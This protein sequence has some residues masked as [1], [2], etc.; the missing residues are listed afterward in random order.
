ML[1]IKGTLIAAL[2]LA[3]LACDNSSQPKI[4]LVS[5]IPP[6]LG[7]WCFEPNERELGAFDAA[8]RAIEFRNGNSE[9]GWLFNGAMLTFGYGISRTGGG[10]TARVCIPEAIRVRLE[11]ALN[12]GSGLG[13]GRPVDYQLI[14]AAELSTPSKIIVDQ[15]AKVAFYNSIQGGEYIRQMQDIR[16]LALTVLAGFGEKAVAYQEQAVRNMN[17]QTSLGTGAA[18]VAVA[19]GAPDALVRV[20]E[21]LNAELDKSPPSKPI[22]YET[23]NRLLELAW[24]IYLAGPSAKNYVQG[25]HKIMNRKVESPAPPFGMLASD[26]YLFCYVLE[27]IEGEQAIQQYDFCDAQKD[28]FRL[29]GTLKVRRSS[30]WGE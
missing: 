14:V 3:L 25:I 27:K 15:V 30:G 13:V 29:P 28:P 22:P 6:K 17:S 26:P 10:Y 11:N 2:A 9:G 12:S 21:L 16:P 1:P 19:T 24:A 20:A 18:Q 23:S 8:V 7:H 5:A 4:E